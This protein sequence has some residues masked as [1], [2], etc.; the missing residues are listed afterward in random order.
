[1]INEIQR[2]ESFEPIINKKSKIL[3]LGTMPSV[4]SLEQ[5]TYY[6]NKK[7]HFWDFM[8]RILLDNYPPYQPFDINTCKQ[9]RYNLLLSNSIAIWDI[10]SSCIRV[11]SNDNK[12]K[13][14]ILNDVATFISQWNL[15]LV[16]CNGKEAFNYLRKSGQYKLINVPVVSLNST[17]SLNSNN[18]FEILNEWMS[19]IKN[20]TSI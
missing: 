5:K 11:G 16:I 19:C 14:E 15:Q 7:N 10:I 9:E 13:D 6:A 2:I 3:I 18:T 17:S 8:Y 20:Q 1:M 12:I 4:I